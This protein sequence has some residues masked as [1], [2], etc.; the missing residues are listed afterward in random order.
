[1]CNNYTFFIY[2]GKYLARRKATK[3]DYFIFKINQIDIF[4]IIAKFKSIPSP[5][6]SSGMTQGYFQ[7]KVTAKITTL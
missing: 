3:A 5:K 1:M 2:N 7:A 6:S 4:Y